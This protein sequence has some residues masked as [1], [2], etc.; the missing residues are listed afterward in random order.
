[1]LADV[2]FSSDERAVVARVSGEVDLSNA[3]H[4]AQVILDATPNHSV[5]LVLDLSE[6]DYLDS[7]GIQMIYQMR[8]SLRARGQLLRMVI[9]STSATGDALGLASVTRFIETVE[10]VDEALGELD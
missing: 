4:I 6:L 8:E 1:M 7:A 9:P 2:R 3:E 10:T 5:A